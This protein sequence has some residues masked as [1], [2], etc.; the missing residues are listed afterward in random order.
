M[1]ALEMIW[2]GGTCGVRLADVLEVDQ[3]ARRRERVAQD[4]FAG[5]EGGLHGVLE[6]R[7]DVLDDRVAGGLGFGLL[8]RPD[9]AHAEAEGERAERHWSRLRERAAPNG[10]CQ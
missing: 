8:G 2:R 1:S 3:E 4:I 10:R 7:L 6:Q 5:A 9:E